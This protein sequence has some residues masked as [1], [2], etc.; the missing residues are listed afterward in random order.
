MLVFILLSST[1][2]NLGKYFKQVY[3]YIKYFEAIQRIELYKFKFLQLLIKILHDPGFFCY[4][5]DHSIKEKF[6]SK[7]DVKYRLK[8]LLVVK[9]VKIVQSCEIY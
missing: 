3:Q 4:L 2:Y 9:S 7:L 1:P 8:S 6:V 5:L